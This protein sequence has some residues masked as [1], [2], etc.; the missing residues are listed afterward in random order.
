MAGSSWLLRLRLSCCDEAPERTIAIGS[1]SL[2]GLLLRFIGKFR[3]H[4]ADEPRD[5]LTEPAL[6]HGE[7]T[8][9]S[10]EPRRNTTRRS[11]CGTACPA[12]TPH[13][14]SAGKAM[15]RPPEHRSLGPHARAARALAGSDAPNTPNGQPTDGHTRGPLHRLLTKP[16]P[17]SRRKPVPREGRCR[18]RTVRSVSF[19]DDPPSR[20]TSVGR[21][22]AH[23]WKRC[24]PARAPVNARRRDL[25]LA[26]LALRPRATP[27]SRREPRPVPASSCLIT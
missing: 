17:R 25:R 14:D 4:A 15:T 20:F 11:D 23:L 5:R 18:Q 16:H 22:A 8:T 10:T 21:S 9:P 1:A 26:L 13:P 24:E 27:A 7:P 19:R 6:Y 3:G 12:P 2:F